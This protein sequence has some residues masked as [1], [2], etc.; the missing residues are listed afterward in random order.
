DVTRATKEIEKAFQNRTS[1]ENYNKFITSVKNLANK[2]ELS[3][4]NRATDKIKEH[5][6]YDLRKDIVDSWTK[7]QFEKGDIN[8]SRKTLL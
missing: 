6:G 8:G 5:T 1:P 7:S 4:A 2:D 3:A